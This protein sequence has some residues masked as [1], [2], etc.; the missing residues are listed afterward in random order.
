MLC[1]PVQ[2]D[3]LNLGSHRLDPRYHI[4]QKD[5]LQYRSDI[6]NCKF[7]PL[8]KLVVKNGI[9]YPGRN[10]RQYVPDPRSGTPFLSST[11][12]F[13]A[14]LLSVKYISSLQVQSMPDLLI[15]EGEILVSRS[16]NTG[17]VQ[18]VDS[19]LSDC[20]ASEHLMRLKPNS[21]VIE[22]GYLYAILKTKFGKM[23]L[24]SETYAS[25]IRHIEPNH[26]ENLEI[27]LFS[28]TERKAIHEMIEKSM[29]YRKK[30]QTELSKSEKILLE[31]VG[32]STSAILDIVHT[33]RHFIELD[34]NF[35]SRFFRPS[36][37]LG[38]SKKLKRL[39]SK[40]ET[41][42]LSDVVVPGSLKRGPRFKRQSAEFGTRMIGQRHL[43]WLVPRGQILRKGSMPEGVFV[44]KDTILVCAQG[45]A[46]EGN[47]FARC[48]IITPS[49]V[50]L[51]FSEHFLR[52]NADSSILLPEVLFTFLRSELGYRLLLDTKGGSILQEFVP[53]L[54]NKLPIPIP[55]EDVQS[56]VAKHVK[57]ALRAL[58]NS[59]IFEKKAIRKVELLL[60]HPHS[61]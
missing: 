45:G 10:V 30:Y 51:A 26:V 40:C 61:L 7:V 29:R 37:F 19:R 12:I 60:I 35:D 38:P 53:E 58:D 22:P 42:S 28:E 44:P 24:S 8:R 52:I 6:G 4:L 39:L 21:E 34:V 25:I 55:S 14:D 59:L 18:F 5:L 46:D 32:I 16:G 3:R 13:N 15:H 31:W 17:E 33:E 20:A 54:L 56:K 9:S 48:R 57:N 47:T 2:S 11:R 36:N 49:M 43:L 23:L 41:K 27:P 1:I 50:D